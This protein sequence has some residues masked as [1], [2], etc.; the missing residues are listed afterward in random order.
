MTGNDASCDAGGPA[1]APA[2]RAV[3][4]RTTVPA[5]A[6]INLRRLNPDVVLRSLLSVMTASAADR[7][8]RTPTPHRFNYNNEFWFQ[9]L[10]FQLLAAR[11]W[12]PR[13][14][15][16]QLAVTCGRRI[17]ATALHSHPPGSPRLLW[18]TRTRF[19]PSS[20]PSTEKFSL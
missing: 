8:R 10:G 11:V 2:V 19:D 12:K 20:S 1:A 5:A 18:V 3:S 9:V 7:E 13:R 14:I 4:G 6:A 15:P 17:V 16:S